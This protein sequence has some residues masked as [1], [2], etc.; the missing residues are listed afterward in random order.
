M[1]ALRWNI[2]QS[3]ERLWWQNYLSRRDKRH[4]LSWKKNYW[5]KVL[6]KVF[7]LTGEE[8]AAVFKNETLQILD[9]GCGPSGIFL[10]LKQH[11]VDALDPLMNQYLEKHQFVDKAEYPNVRFMQGKLENFLR[12]GIYDYV[13][14]MNCI[15]HVDDI[16]RCLA[17]MFAA[18]KNNGVLALTV[19]THKY[20]PLK[21]L[22]KIV[23][24]DILHP[25]QW[26]LEQ[27]SRAI[28]HHFR[29]DAIRHRLL[30]RGAFFDHYML[31]VQK[32]I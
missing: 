32:K 27:Y 30:K 26:N 25:Y 20:E 5:E 24:A 23:P 31:V 13:F 4:Y 15:N 28:R 6:H 7:E 22:L 12:N 2:A 29:D 18:L 1:I 8:K 11:R 21:A 3:F 19:D 16:G 14:C 17:N 9:A 10:N